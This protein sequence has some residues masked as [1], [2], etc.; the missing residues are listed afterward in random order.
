MRVR[1]R[2]RVCVCDQAVWEGGRS[3]LGRG[4]A[5]AEALR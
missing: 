1:V 4:M 3:I 5:G 2:L